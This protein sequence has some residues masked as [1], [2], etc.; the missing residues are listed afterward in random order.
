MSCL[1][2]LRVFS[3][4]DAIDVKLGRR[5]PDCIDF[6]EDWMRE[7]DQ[8]RGNIVLML[9]MVAAVLWTI[10]ALRYYAGL[11]R[12]LDIAEFLMVGFIPVLCLACG[13]TYKRAQQ[14]GRPR[15]GTRFD[16]LDPA[17]L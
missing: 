2:V 14:D 9:S 4:P 6:R 13:W 11:G 8:R 1:T 5:D 10:V 16:E 12:P 15:P 7:K 17:D 3:C